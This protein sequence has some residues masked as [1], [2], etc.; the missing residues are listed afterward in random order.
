M[1]A[2]Q[3]GMPVGTVP[4]GGAGAPGAYTQ[5]PPGQPQY[6]QGGYGAQYGQPG[7]PGQWAPPSGQ[8]QWGQQQGPYGQGQYG[9]GQYGQVQ[10]GQPPTGPG[11]FG[12][13]QF[14]QPQ[15]TPPKRS[16]GVMAALTV[17]AVV[18]L[19]GGA[20]VAVKLVGNSS[21]TS[22]PTSGPTTGGPTSV[23]PTTPPTSSS[24]PSAAYLQARGINNLLERS[25]GS[26]SRLNNAIALANQCQDLTFAVNQIQQVRNGRQAELNQ[27]QTLP[28]DAL[29]N[30]AQL[31]SYLTQAL[32]YSL[33]ADNDY[34]SWAQAQ[35]S[36]CAPGTSGNVGI[37]DGSNAGATKYKELFLG[38]WNPMANQYG[39]PQRSSI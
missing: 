28:T 26:L 11:Q 34:L 3:P 9:Q 33:T 18:I 37:S 35:E 29:T 24:G 39:F 19:A 32:Q 25:S 38:L 30:G 8:G 20:V 5:A 2:A 13:S 16:R 22:G 4:P 31:K 14:T 15:P 7:A 17:A 12:P 6:G 21:S 23:P 27:A 10:Y 1:L 36:S